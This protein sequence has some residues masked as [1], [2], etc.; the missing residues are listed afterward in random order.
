MASAFARRELAALLARPE[1]VETLRAW[2][3]Q[4]GSWDRAAAVL[5]VHRNSVRHRIGHVERL[6]GRDLGSADARAALWLALT[7]LD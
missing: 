4:H 6:L 7:W 1:L 2:L 3:A 5:G